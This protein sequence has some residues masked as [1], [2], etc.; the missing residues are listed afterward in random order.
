M[1]T[2]PAPR[3]TL[4]RALR[5]TLAEVWAL[6]TT[7]EGVE[8]WWGPPGFKVTV[9]QLDL[10][11]G[12]SLLYTMT[13]VEPEMV[14]FMHANGMPVATQTRITYT[15]VV[16]QRRLAYVNHVD[17][18]PEVTAYDVG[19]VIE[20]SPTP[21]G[22]ALKLTLDPMHNPEWT[23]RAVMGWEG[24]LGKLVSLLEARHAGPEA[25]AV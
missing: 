24:E 2:T 15:E 8:S 1:S 23:Q 18:V 17:F 19:T 4:E 5:G 16:A 11:P 9:Q 20:L 21:T 14:A 13:A 25:A 22:V 12:G 10:W 7:P 6:W 3:I